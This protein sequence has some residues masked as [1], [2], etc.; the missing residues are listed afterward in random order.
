MDK[1]QLFRSAIWD[2]SHVMEELSDP[3]LEA[4]RRHKL[5]RARG[6]SGW[7]EEWLTYNDRADQAATRTRVR[8]SV[9]R[10]AVARVRQVDDLARRALK[11]AAEVVQCASPRRSR[12]Q[13]V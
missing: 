13:I 1:S 9:P 7:R 12:A 2:P 10:E 5:Q 8:H 6:Q 3:E 11:A 4:K